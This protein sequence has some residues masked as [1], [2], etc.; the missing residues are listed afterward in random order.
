MRS[1]DSMRFV[2]NTAPGAIT[3]MQLCTFNQVV[4]GGFE[5]GASHGYLTLNVT[6]TGQLPA[7]YTI[8]VSAA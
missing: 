2:T 8:T 1:A 3:A 6:N 7:E 5:A 4:C